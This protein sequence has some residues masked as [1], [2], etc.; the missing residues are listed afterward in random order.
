MLVCCAVNLR[1]FKYKQPKKEKLMEYTI[2][3]FEIYAPESSKTE[4][5]SG[6]VFINTNHNN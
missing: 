6:D 2:L 3:K 5:L 4:I 1:C